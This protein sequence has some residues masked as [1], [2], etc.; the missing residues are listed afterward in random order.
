MLGIGLEVEGFTTHHL[1]SLNHMFGFPFA[2]GLWLGD[3]R[4][5]V[6][7]GIYGAGC[8]NTLCPV[9]SNDNHYRYSTVVPVAAGLSRSFVQYSRASNAVS[10]GAAVRY[11]AVN[12]VADTFKG[13]EQFWMHGPV[14]APYLGATGAFGGVREFMVIFEVPV[15]YA[16]AGNGDSTLTVGFGLVVLSVL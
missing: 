5:E 2:L 8:P 3:Y 16:F 15:G 10:L 1:G 6:G 12:L 4:I 11:R 13:Q 14:L 9:T 7:A